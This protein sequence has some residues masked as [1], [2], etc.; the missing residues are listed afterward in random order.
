MSE[1]LASGVFPVDSAEG[2]GVLKYEMPP[3]LETVEKEC[4][5]VSAKSECTP[6]VAACDFIVGKPKKM[7][8]VGKVEGKT[9]VD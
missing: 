6:L 7:K 9:L 5:I 2:T 8:V 4:Y 1:L 3:V